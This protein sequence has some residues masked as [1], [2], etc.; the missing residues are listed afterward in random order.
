METPV[1]PKYRRQSTVGSDRAFVVLNG[2]RHYLGQFDSPD[3]K[4]TYHRLLAEWT[5]I[6]S[7]FHR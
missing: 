5:A 2:V 1:F 3:S 7:E 4:A 6:R